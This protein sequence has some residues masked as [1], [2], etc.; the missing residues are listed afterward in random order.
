MTGEDYFIPR[1]AP[2]FYFHLNTARFLVR[3]VQG[4]WPRTRTRQVASTN[5]A[6]RMKLNPRA[7]GVNQAPT[8]TRKPLGAPT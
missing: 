7:R 5:A 2:N 1:A 4:N 6:H 8:S 3:L